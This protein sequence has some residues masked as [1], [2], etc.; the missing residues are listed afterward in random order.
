MS[1]RTA[2]TEPHP[3]DF[4]GA[5][6]CTYANVAALIADLRDVEAGRE[7]IAWRDRDCRTQAGV[8]ATVLQWLSGALPSK[9]ADQLDP[10]CPEC[11]GKGWVLHPDPEAR[12]WERCGCTLAARESTTGAAHG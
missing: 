11:S 3:D 12:S 9:Q 8:L 6:H 10:A 2:P 5:H 1:W 4:A 7:T